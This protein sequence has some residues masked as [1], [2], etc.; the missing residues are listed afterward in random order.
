MGWMTLVLNR[1]SSYIEAG[2]QPAQ[3]LAW[4]K[5]L[6]VGKPEAVQGGLPTIYIFFSQDSVVETWAAAQGII[7][8]RFTID[9]GVMCPSK[10]TVTNEE[11]GRVLERYGTGTTGLIPYLESLA[12]Y[13][14]SIYDT[15]KG[16]SS[17]VVDI[18]P[19]TIQVGPPGDAGIMEGAVRLT[20]IGRFAKGSR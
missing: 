11:T 1:V 2:M 9:L 16:S 15:I 10:E 20:I 7:S 17:S 13:L 4:A 8:S 18:L 6:V 14:D 19:P 5:S 12:N 3:P